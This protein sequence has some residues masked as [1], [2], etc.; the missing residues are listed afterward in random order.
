MFIIGNYLDLDLDLLLRS[1]WMKNFPMH[2]D[3]DKR[4][5]ETCEK[6]KNLIESSGDIECM[7]LVDPSQM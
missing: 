3:L 7:K 6:M 1:F 4:L 2:F 5:K